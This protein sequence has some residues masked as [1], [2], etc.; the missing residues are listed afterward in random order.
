M[1]NIK[2]DLFPNV[3]FNDCPNVS[4]LPSLYVGLAVCRELKPR[5]TSVR[6]PKPTPIAAHPMLL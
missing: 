3:A 1:T 4:P 6:T 5:Q 2:N